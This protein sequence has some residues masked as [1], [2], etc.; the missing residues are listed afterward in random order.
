MKKRK[1]IGRKAT[2]V[3]LERAS[4]E[5][6]FKPIEQAIPTRAAFKELQYLYFFNG[7]LAGWNSELGVWAPSDALIPIKNCAVQAEDFIKFIRGSNENTI[8]LIQHKDKLTVRTE[9]IEATFPIRVAKETF[10]TIEN[11]FSDPEEHSWTKLPKQV[12]KGIVLCSF[13]THKDLSQEALRG[14]Y[15]DSKHCFSTDS[16]RMGVNTF[17][18]GRIKKPFLLPA[19]TAVA[20]KVLRPSYFC[21]VEKKKAAPVLFLK[22]D[23]L[24]ACSKLL[25]TV[26][27]FDTDFFLK[28]KRESDETSCDVVE[29]PKELI[30]ALT[31]TMIFLSDDY[32]LD[33]IIN[34]T[35]DKTGFTISVKRE[36]RGTYKA[37][38]KKKLKIKKFEMRVN[39]VLLLEAFK[40]HNS[41]FAVFKTKKNNKMGYALGI[42]SGCFQHFLST[43]GKETDDEE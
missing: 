29:P 33:R 43:W 23:K 4:L 38:I 12:V 16:Y 5:V 36:E 32:V 21:L 24:F 40:H 42:K 37:H 6:L 15:V 30:A 2:A 9:K 7:G 18:T 31:N 25:P 20:F 17:K 35:L 28:V 34:L 19:D 27:K 39:P 14:V 26:S 22:S 3:T 41:A 11:L 8:E 10:K 1:P 13:S